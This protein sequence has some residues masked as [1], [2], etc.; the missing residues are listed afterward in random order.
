MRHVGLV[1]P[2][3]IPPWKWKDICMD[4]IV[5]LPLTERKFNSIGVI[6]DRLTKSAHFIPV[7]TFYLTE[8]YAKLYVSHM[9]CLHSVPKTIITDRGPSSSLVSGNSCMLPWEHI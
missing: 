1:Q 5:G 8:K 6:V 3:S 7:H 9:L 2:L 4:F